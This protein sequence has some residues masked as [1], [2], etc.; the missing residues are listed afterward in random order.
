MAFGALLT[1]PFVLKND[2]MT[3]FVPSLPG[4]QTLRAIL[5]LASTAFFFAGLNYLSVADTLAIFFVQPL[6]LTLLSPLVLGE[7]V[8]DNGGLRIALY[9]LQDTLAGKPATPVAGFTPEQRFFIGFGQS[10]CETRRD[11]Y[12]RMLAQV[13]VHSPGRFRING[14]VANMPEFAKA[15]G[16][17]PGAPMVR[18]EKACRVW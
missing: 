17:K 16:C 7:N 1:L 2:G 18:A 6:V 13:D 12:S 5:L 10:W 3:A 15:F 11:E 9:A 14:T 4:Y 8:A